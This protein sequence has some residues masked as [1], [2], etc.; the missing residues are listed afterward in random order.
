MVA[1]G[2]ALHAVDHPGAQRAFLL[3]HGLASNLRLWDGVAAHL[4]AEGHRV[5]AVDLRGH[6]RSDK[7][8]DGYDVGTV[9]A[10]LATLVQ[11]LALDRPWVAGQSW[12]GNVA[13][14][15]AWGH[16]ALVSGVACV[17][18]GWIELADRFPDWE[19]CRRALAPPSRWGTV[20]E[21]EH[22]L[23]RA[24]PGWPETGIQGALAC[25]E[26]TPGGG[27]RPWLTL[28]RH[29]LVLEG[30]WRHRPST[31]YP[32]VAVPVLLVPA[33]RPGADPMG[34]ADAVA[35]AEATLPTSRT[36]WLDGDHDVHAQHPD[37]VAAAL[38]AAAGELA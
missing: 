7:P 27:A 34:T 11:E 35:R 31:R 37:R 19:A 3:V 18:G 1:P 20:A 2:V 17:D 28:E 22:H 4:A 21:I 26:V 30:L 5:V 16:A 29:L 10:D 6:G 15:L 25:F 24:H 36:T 38:L 9:A 8:D 23:R 12:G 32:E 14:E 33:R 13:L